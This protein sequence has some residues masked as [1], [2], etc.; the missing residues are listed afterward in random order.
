MSVA[1]SC[2]RCAPPPVCSPSAS[3][4][5]VAVSNALGSSCTLVPQGT[6]LLT[7]TNAHH[8]NVLL[9]QV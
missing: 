3:H 2:S 5:A 9:F 1:R 7:Y 6:V 4:L 8:F